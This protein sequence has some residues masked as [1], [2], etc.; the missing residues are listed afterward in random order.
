MTKTKP[1]PICGAPALAKYMPFCSA[2]C[3]NIDL[4]RWLNENYRI[5]ARS[6][7]EDK[8]PED[9]ADHP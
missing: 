1:C 2:R 5:P 6:D 3:A 4:G 9:E 8:A 7:I